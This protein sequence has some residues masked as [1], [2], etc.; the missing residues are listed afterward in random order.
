M[1]LVLCRHAKSEWGNESLSDFDRPLNKR[2]MKNSIAMG[3]FLNTKEIEFDLLLSS[4]ALRAHTTAKRVAQGIDYS[5]MDIVLESDLYLAEIE[6]ILKS[7]EKHAVGKEHVLVF[8]HNPGFTELVNYFGVRLDNLPTNGMVAFE[9]A[10]DSWQDLH[11]KEAKYLWHQ[12]P[13]ML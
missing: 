3:E 6:T 1:L 7:I 13:R 9:I 5:E 2:G 4:S 10:G 8:G 11:R 12:F